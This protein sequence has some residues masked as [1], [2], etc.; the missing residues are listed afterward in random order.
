M[1]IRS[2]RLIATEIPF[3]EVQLQL[4]CATES[5][6]TFRLMD[7]AGQNKPFITHVLS[8]LPWNASCKI[9]QVWT[10]ASTRNKFEFRT[11]DSELDVRI[12]VPCPTE[13]ND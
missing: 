3:V 4:M 1:A 9:A 2:F 5:N 11:G 7:C 12:C 13:A 6:T 8:D 10:D